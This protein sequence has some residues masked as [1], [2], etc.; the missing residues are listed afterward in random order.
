MN[1][2][3]PTTQSAPALLY[4]VVFTSRVVL[5]V[6]LFLI[7]TF[8]LQPI[9]RAEAAEVEVIPETATEVSVDELVVQTEIPLP[10][11]TSDAAEI[12]VEAEAPPVLDVPEDATETVLLSD[13]PSVVSPGETRGEN[14]SS[15]TV[16][17]NELATT[18]PTTSD[19]PP[20]QAGS[21]SSVPPP[22]QEG[23]SDGVEGVT[24]EGLS[25]PDAALATTTSEVPT[26]TTATTSATATESLPLVHETYSDS[27]VRFL[28]RDCVTVAGG[29]YY[30]Q[31]RSAGGSVKD[32]LIAEPDSGGDLEIFL[33]KDGVYH[34]LTNND[35]DDASPSYDGR[36]ETMV[37]HR[38]VGDAYVIYEYD[39]TTGEERALSRGLDNDM[40]PSRFGNRTVWQ[41]WLDGRWQVIL[42][43]NDTETQLTTADAHHVA[44]VIRGEIIMWQ[45]VD[46]LGEKQIETLDLL[47]GAYNTI[48]DSESAALANPRMMMVY[49]AVYEN[50]DVVTRGV[51]LKTGQIVGLGAVPAELPEELP[52]SESTGE[53]RALV[54]PK[55]T[56]KEGESEGE[57]EPVPVLPPVATSSEALTLDLRVDEPVATTTYL[58]TSTPAFTE[59]DL[60]IQPLSLPIESTSTTTT[61]E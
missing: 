7:L 37:W 28:K 32:A 58:G 47:T 43:E 17:V 23:G 53:T 38:L 41:R 19:P 60:V 14:I 3:L 18:T 33:V 16:V 50:G 44:P 8:T 13:P 55:P 48:N 54:S 26:D 25:S 40:E 61:T 57:G 36:S 51:D 45:T 52:E 59:S 42:Y 31:V 4:R 24:E 46:G 6:T 29:A 21:D 11:D 5:V 49:E 10:P 12:A 34:Q 15:S 2:R 1:P 35:V 20:A 27:E 30:C 9:V 56:P 22:V 39:F